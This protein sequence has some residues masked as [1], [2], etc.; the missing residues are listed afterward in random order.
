[1]KE[2]SSSRIGLAS[3]LLK[4]V[5]AALAV[6]KELMDLIG[7]ALNYDRLHAKIL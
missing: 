1:M 5:A 7:P 2:T 6:V 3:E 4:L